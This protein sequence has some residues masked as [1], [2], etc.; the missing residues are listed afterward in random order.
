[1]ELLLP[2]HDTHCA[3]RFIKGRYPSQVRGTNACRTR[4][5]TVQESAGRTRAISG[6]VEW[7]LLFRFSEGGLGGLANEM[8]RRREQS[9]A[10]REEYRCKQYAKETLGLAHSGQPRRFSPAS[11]QRDRGF[12]ERRQRSA[13]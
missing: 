8:D 4:R 11:A 5:D 12:L 10:D 2:G 1:M 9:R 7:L 3:L 13:L 6:K